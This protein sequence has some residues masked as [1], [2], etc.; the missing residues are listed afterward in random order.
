MSMD[1]ELL[2]APKGIEM[3]VIVLSIVFFCYL[4]IAPKG[5]EI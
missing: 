5:I 1:F 3:Q 2:I 4:L